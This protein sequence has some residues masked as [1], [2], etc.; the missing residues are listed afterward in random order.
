M[1]RKSVIALAVAATTTVGF[2]ATVASANSVVLC[3]NKTTDVVR[4][5]STGKCRAKT[6]RRLTLGVTGP[7]GATG[8]QGVKGDTGD[9]GPAGA[10]VQAG[11]YSCPSG[12]YMASIKFAS[13]GAA[14]QITCFDLKSGKNTTPTFTP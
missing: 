8:P 14:P 11:T 2:G 1:I 12:S 13:N 9:T 5:S 7:A 6:E 10:G 4:Y 3:A